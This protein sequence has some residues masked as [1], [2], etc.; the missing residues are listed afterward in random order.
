MRQPKKIYHLALQT[1]RKK[2]LT[3]LTHSFQQEQGSHFLQAN[4]SYPA[5]VCFC[6]L[7]CSSHPC[8][9]DSHNLWKKK[10]FKGVKCNFWWNG[11]YHCTDMLTTS[12]QFREREACCLHLG[13]TFTE[14]WERFIIWC[15]DKHLKRKTSGE[16]LHFKWE[17]CC[18]EATSLKMLRLYIHV[19]SCRTEDH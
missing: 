13:T 10:I 9:P 2:N 14:D 3:S 15:K 1:L 18:K 19:W 7:S 11:C 6:E 16:L 12:E 8:H 4:K 5:V 17:S